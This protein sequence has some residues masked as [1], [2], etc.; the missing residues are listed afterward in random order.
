MISIL[1]ISRKIVNINLIKIKT[2][3]P[4]TAN[5]SKPGI[6]GLTKFI[7]FSGTLTADT[8]VA[9]KLGLLIFADVCVQ[10]YVTNEP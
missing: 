4:T 9:R 10:R 7:T 8:N 5:I 3:I 1:M 6:Y 2:H